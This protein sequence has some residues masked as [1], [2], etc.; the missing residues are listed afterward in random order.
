MGEGDDFV[1]GSVDDEDGDE[2]MREF[3]DVGEHVEARGVDYAREENAD[4]G[5]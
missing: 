4:A 5:G 2:E 1:G 3:V